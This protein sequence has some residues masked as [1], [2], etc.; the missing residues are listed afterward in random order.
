[1]LFVVSRS[2]S[3]LIMSACI[4]WYNDMTTC[5]K[6]LVGMPDEERSSSWE[7]GGNGIRSDGPSCRICHVFLSFFFSTKC[8]R[9]PRSASL[10][11]A[12]VGRFGETLLF[13]TCVSPV[14]CLLHDVKVCTFRVEPRFFPL[15]RGGLYVSSSGLQLARGR[16][17]IS[18]QFLFSLRLDLCRHMLSPIRFPGCERSFHRKKW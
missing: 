1:M 9:C 2:R 11:K 8:E 17:R 3:S 7:R 16:H 18:V 10:L 15:S 4:S 14:R 5:F 13:S 6:H 12:P